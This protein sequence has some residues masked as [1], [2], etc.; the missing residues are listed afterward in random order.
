MKPSHSWSAAAYNL[1][2]YWY[3]RG[4]LARFCVRAGF[5][6][7][8]PLPSTSEKFS[9]VEDDPGFPKA[10]NL[11]V[12]IRYSRRP[13]GAAAVECKFSEPFGRGH[14]GLADR[15]LRLDVWDKLPHIKGVARDISPGDGRFEHFHA[16]Q[17]IKHI[18]GLTTSVGRGGFRLLY[19]WYDVPGEESAGHRREITE[20]AA[21]ARADGVDFHSRTYQEVI[22]RMEKLRSDH[23]A[24]VDYMAER[25][26]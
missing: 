10:P 14:G 24:Y 6:P 12:A 7:P 26:L 20:F 5:R 15:Y 25:Y 3:S 21:A 4:E 13:V 8:M 1:F 18:L 17:I 23:S 9:I 16:A 22:L 11:D 19:L 2:G